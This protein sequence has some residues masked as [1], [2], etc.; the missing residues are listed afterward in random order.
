M[1]NAEASNSVEKDLKSV[2]LWQYDQSEHLVGIVEMLQEFFRASTEGLWDKLSSESSIVAYNGSEE[3]APE[4]VSDFALSVFG[5]KFSFDR[6]SLNYGTAVSPD[7]R[8][9]S[10]ELYRRILV[11][12]M[13]LLRSNASIDAYLAFTKYIFGENVDITTT[14]DMGIGLHWWE[15]ADDTKPDILEMKLAFE[16]CIDDIMIYPTGVKS[17]VPSDSAVF[18]FDGQSP[19][20]AG[21]PAIGGLDNSSFD[22][23]RQS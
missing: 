3:V 18:G 9:M 13:R 15:D 12:R 14:E 21:D 16:Q 8:P 23:R 1:T 11:A 4:E 20:S 17:S 10:S 5:K 22:W 7:M 2:I 19:V 6:P